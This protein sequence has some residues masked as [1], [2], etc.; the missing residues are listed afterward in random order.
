MCPSVDIHEQPCRKLNFSV[1]DVEMVDSG[2]TVFKGGT[3]LFRGH[4][5]ICGV[6]ARAK[7]GIPPSHGNAEFGMMALGQI[8]VSS[9]DSDGD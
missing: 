9:P 8:V 2:L 3:S 5:S 1:G 7:H 6:S 4:V